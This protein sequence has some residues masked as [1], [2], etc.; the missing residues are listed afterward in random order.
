MTKKEKLLSFLLDRLSLDE[1]FVLLW[2]GRTDKDNYKSYVFTSPVKSLFCYEK[3]ELINTLA[4]IE[5]FQRQGYYIAGFISYEAGLYLDDAMSDIHPQEPMKFPLLW[6]GIYKDPI[7]YNH[8]SKSFNNS[9][10]EKLF[11]QYEPPNYQNCQIDNIT[12]NVE[13]DDYISKIASIISAIERGET[14][15]VNYTFKHKFKLNDYTKKLFFSL[16][17][18]Q[19]ASYSAFIRC[20]YWDILSLSPELLFIRNDN[21]ITV[22]PMKGT[23]RRGVSNSEDTIRSNELY[24]SFK[25]RAENVMIVDLLRNDIGKMSKIGSVNVSKLYEIEKYE[26]L[27]QMTSTVESELK[28]GVNWL[29][30]FKNIFPSGSVTGAPKIKTM[31]IINNL[32]K[33]PRGVYTGSIGFIAPDNASVFNVAIRTVVLDRNSNNGEMGIGSGIVYDSGAESEFH[34]CLLKSNFLTSQFTDFQL[35]ETILWEKG[36]FYLLDLH[37]RRLRDSAEYF[38]FDYDMDYIDN[39]LNQESTAFEHNAKYRVRLLLFRDGTIT[40]TSTKLDDP[41]DSIRLVT[42]SHIQTNPDDRFLYHKTTNRKLYDDEFHRAR[43][44]GYY[45]F[46]FINSHGEVTEGTISNIFILKEGQLYTPPLN[47]GLLNGVFRQYMLE[48]NPK[49]EEKVLYEKDI[50]EAEKLYLTNS[51]RGMTEVVF[52]R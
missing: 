36:D 40:I 34:E 52:N 19:S 5:Q 2:N 51:V 12:S 7:I 49:V 9:D 3:D 10:I 50:I 39:L 21:H 46:L 29:D 16:C 17:M 23:I 47:C 24:N 8:N 25:D 27:F 28:D 41:D 26:T 42:F 14:Y 1:Q 38:I 31:H 35:I 48:N 13:K 37:L 43:V 22:K 44:K 15:Q 32:E 45:D 11:A 4:S 6:F 33:E 20:D 30:F 18:K